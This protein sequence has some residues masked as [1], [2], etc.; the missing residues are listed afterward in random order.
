MKKFLIGLLAGMLLTVLTMFVLFFAMVRAGER[1]PRVADG[2]TLVLNLEG[3]IP[4]Q[5]PI[6]LPFPMLQA[7]EAVTV[8]DIWDVL[9]KAT[10][11]SRIKAIVLIPQNVGAGWAKLQEIREGLLK[12]K[13]SGKTLVAF[14]R[15]AGG[16]EYYLATAADRIYMS[17]EDVL[18]V[19]GL[20]AELVFLKNTLDK[21]GVQIEIEHA[22]KYKDAGDMF[23]RTSM[24]PETREVLDSV[25]DQ[26]Y[27]GFLKAVA[28]GRRLDVE[29]VKALIDQGPF[30][31]RK[32]KEMR[33]IDDLLFEDKVYDEVKKRLGQDEIRKISYRDYLRV[34]AS[35][36]GLD[37]GPRVA[38]LVGEGAILSGDE[39]AFGEEG[40]LYS[41]AFIRTIRSVAEDD[42]I[43]GVILR[44]NSPGGDALASDEM[45]HELKALSRKKPVVVSMSDLAAS[46][47][48][49]IA[50]T[51][52]RVL[53]Y[54]DTLT[55]SIG[56]V[57]G[58]ANLKGLYDKLGVRKEI[59][60][61]GRFADIDSDYKPLTDAGREKLREGIEEIY[62]GFLQVVADG[63]KRKV[64][65]V[66]P[67]AE[68]RVWTGAQARDKGL[69]D[70][71][72]GLDRSIE[73]LKRRAGI[74]ADV[75]VRLV[76][77]PPKRSLLSYLIEERSG[78]ASL[79]TGLRSITRGINP[80]VLLR[81]GTLKL[82]PYT[83][84]VK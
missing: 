68:G 69:V 57:F 74:A 43:R 24:T 26:F 14:L 55:G 39:P 45:L 3:E 4:E 75:K 10:V 28:D 48:Y 50:M 11:D 31:S 34:P 78:L 30:L 51:G 77:Y 41:R 81:G 33:L 25:L 42:G 60:T 70:E 6:S 20:R 27:G 18:Y 71:F 13:K 82:A 15:R 79:A 23:T 67:L 49:Y 22:G 66:R 61:R 52:D 7:R 12:F 59:L 58:K 83:I 72:G 65:Q 47:G 38:L 64:E 37:S 16:R 80:E 35:G 8:H 5:P 62:R 36:L 76:T 46:G 84:E 54:P 63:R 21:V 44:I 29:K 32:A 17:G 2:S 53:S 40:A 56:V 9:R 19:K 73:V 1:R